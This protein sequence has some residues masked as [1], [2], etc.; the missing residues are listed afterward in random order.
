MLSNFHYTVIYISSFFTV[1]PFVFGL[2]LHNKFKKT[3]PMFFLAI[4]SAV[5]EVLNIL[6]SKYGITMIYISQVYTVL[7]FILIYYF[8][9]SYYKSQ[10]YKKA[11]YLIPPLY[12]FYNFY[13][14][15]FG[16]VSN[17]FD[18]PS[19]I[20]ESIFFIIVSLLSFVFLVKYRINELIINNP[21]FWVNSGILIYFS[22]NILLFMFY[23]SIQPNDFFMLYVFLH[24][25]LNIIYNSLLCVSF[26]KSK[27]I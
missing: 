25:A 8:Y 23:K 21:F 26:Y 6:L 20:I 15:M 18:N 4:T 19:L 16:N 9:V 3:Q 10:Y 22:G 24:S 2:L 27:Q 11:L 17:S 14:F 12:F 7:E 5:F 13:E 1:L